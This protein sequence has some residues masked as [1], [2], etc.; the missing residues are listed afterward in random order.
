MSSKLLRFRPSW[1][2]LALAG[3]AM[4]A[5]SPLSAAPLEVARQNELKKVPTLRPVV[6]TRW[7]TTTTTVRDTTTGLTWERAPSEAKLDWNAAKSKCDGLVLG[8]SSDWRIPRIEELKTLFETD[9]PDT[10]LATGHPFTVSTQSRW[11]ATGNPANRYTV[12]VSN[13]NLFGSPTS[14]PVAVWCVRGGANTTYPSSNPRFQFVD[15]TN[16]KQVLDTQTSLAWRTQPTTFGDWFHA[17]EECRQEGPG[18]R[19][20]TKDEYVGLMDPA[21]PGSPKL[22]VG[23][24]FNNTYP[25][26]YDIMLRWSSTQPTTAEATVV[27]LSDAS[28]STTA[29][30][31]GSVSG[32]CVKG[33]PAAPRFSLV[34]GDTAVLDTDTQLVWTRTPTYVKD[35][36]ANQKAACTAKDTA[37]AS[38]WRLPTVNEF[39]TI[40][41]YHSSEKPELVAG[42]LFT[43]LQTS[44]SQMMWTADPG[45]S[46]A[47]KT[48]DIYSAYVSQGGY[49]KDN[50][51][52]AW[53]V[54]SNLQ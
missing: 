48:V 45:S 39:L 53:C 21:A 30:L 40:V 13:G 16:Y 9:P 2:L 25:P 5:A 50:K 41:D 38:G 14:T 28:V 27:R 8:G 32:F 12:L 46:V 37:G 31:T 44:S 24:P 29:K 26:G 3:L 10:F 36:H 47:F 54:R 22:P 1:S 7:V 34:E 49:H 52:Y 4:L 18:W 20:A 19:L 11:T 35:T 42:H 43:G 17:R 51:H 15:G 23:H 33:D 6:T